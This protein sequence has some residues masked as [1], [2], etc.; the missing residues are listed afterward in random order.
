MTLIN[1]K[2]TRTHKI[3]WFYIDEE[4]TVISPYFF[5]EEESLQWKKENET[6][7]IS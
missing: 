7:Q 5:K 3:M 4:N 6:S 2:D 1:H